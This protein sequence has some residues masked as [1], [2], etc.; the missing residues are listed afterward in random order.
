MPITELSLQEIGIQKPGY[1][2]RLMLAMEDLNRKEEIL[3]SNIMN[4]FKCCTVEVSSNMFMI[5]MPG[6]DKWLETLN[7]KELYGVFAEN[8]YDELDQMLNLMNS[9]WEITAEDL[10]DIGISKPGYRH[11]ILSKLKEDSLGISKRKVQKIKENKI[12]LR[13]SDLC[14]IM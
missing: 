11:R 1:R 9:P 6:L 13:S 5:N 14:Y 8:G 12:S 2:K 7:L 3:T 4:P 10:I